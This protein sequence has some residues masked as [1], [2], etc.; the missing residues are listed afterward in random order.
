MPQEG[1]AS[2]S[3]EADRRG[4][5][6]EQRPPTVSSRGL[7]LISLADFLYFATVLMCRVLMWRDRH[8]KAL[9]GLFL[10]PEVM[11]TMPLGPTCYLSCCGHW[12][13]SL[14]WQFRSATHPQRAKCANKMQ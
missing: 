4:P 7:R 8:K 14:G 3:V 9:L 11:P 2:E 13:Q 12:G 6:E 1:A 10:N 5:A